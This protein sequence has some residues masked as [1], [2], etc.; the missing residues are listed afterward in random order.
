MSMRKVTPVLLGLLLML[1]L[2]AVA[3]A[4]DEEGTKVGAFAIGRGVSAAKAAVDVQYQLRKLATTT[5]TF[6]LVNMQD[7]LDPDEEPPRKAAVAEAMALLEQGKQAYEN[8]EL[9]DAQAKFSQA[10]KKFEYGFGY[11]ERSG[12]LV[13]TLMYQGASYVLVGEP[14]KGRPFFVRAA[15]LPGRKMIDD[16]L[17]PPN[18]QEIFAQVKAEAE[19]GKRAKASL[20]TV[21]QGATVFVDN[22]YRGG[23][24]LQIEDLRPG[25]HLVRAIKDGLRPWGGKI[26]V[27]A[28]RLKRLKLTLKPTVQRKAFSN[29]FRKLAAETLKGAPGPG[30]AEISQFLSAQRLVIVI[31]DGEPAAMKMRG[32]MC[33][34]DEQVRH[35]E[36]KEVM[37]TTSPGYEKQLKAFLIKVLQSNPN[38]GDAADG[39]AA[40]ALIASNAKDPKDDGSAQMGLD[41]SDDGTTEDPKIAQADTSD[42]KSEQDREKEAADKVVKDAGKTEPDDSEQSAA[43]SWT[44][45]HDK[46]W[47]WSAIGVVAAGAAT[48]TYFA[49][50]GSTSDPSGGELILGIH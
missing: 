4:Q 32:L 47:F 38:G 25:V 27:N 21:P 41:L 43:F 17:F 36:I 2:C 7:L 3:Q 13:E 12:Y 50:A 37:D 20:I 26:K 19:A 9:E 16:E 39:A 31:L 10:L 29:V 15:D 14:K 45:L 11:L 24:P 18:I 22:V 1:G 6:Q 40:A 5:G 42:V 30:A 34:I 35:S 48:G 49:V 46:W 33:E 28:K 44:Y 8:L 23:S